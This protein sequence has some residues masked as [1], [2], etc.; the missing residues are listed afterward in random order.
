MNEFEPQDL[1]LMADRWER[2]GRPVEAAL[3]RQLYEKM[4]LTEFPPLIVTHRRMGK[5][6]IKKMYGPPGTLANL[7]DFEDLPNE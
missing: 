2:F 4:S 5:N 7:A 1:P 3:L 6:T